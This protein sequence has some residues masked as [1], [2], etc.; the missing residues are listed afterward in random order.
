MVSYSCEFYNALC[1]E[2]SGLRLPKFST[3]IGTFSCM[4]SLICNELEFLF[5]GFTIRT[6]IRFLSG[7]SYLLSNK[8]IAMGKEKVFFSTLITGI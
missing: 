2:I 6:L 4:S 8:P 1:Y 7:M 3:S 5:E